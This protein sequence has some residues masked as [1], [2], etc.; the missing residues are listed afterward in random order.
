MRRTVLG[1][2]ICLLGATAFGQV[3]QFSDQTIAG[4]P[5]DL[6]VVRHLVIRGDNVSIGKKL[7]QIGRERHHSELFKLPSPAV[8]TEQMNWMRANYPER[9]AR[10]LGVRTAYGLPPHSNYDITFVPID[11]SLKPACSVVFYPGSSVTNGHAMLSRNYDFPKASYAQITGQGKGAGVRSMTGD[12]YVIEMHPDKGFASLFLCAYDLEGAAID[13]VN[14]KGVTVA[15]LSDDMTKDH[16]RGRPGYGLCEADVTRF[17]LDKCAN[18]KEARRLL[19]DIPYFTFFGVCHYIIG[20]A[21]G[22]SFVFEIGPD[23]K[24]YVIDGKG[25][26]QIVTNH[27]I[28]EYG[29]KNLPRGDSFDRYKRLQQE[30]AKRKGKV[31]PLEVKEI[32]SCVAVPANYMV[33]A[34]LWHAVYDLKDLSLKVSFCLSR[35][36]EAKERRTPYLQFKLK[37]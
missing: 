23:G 22:D 32:N 15:L 11:M 7:A 3:T 5:K 33:S 28:A 37:S 1:L 4:T 35:A 6:M 2:G 17:V 16:K 14:A 34:T 13:G 8:G 36:D 27:S 18:A 30:E 12:P 9:Y 20:D 19:K 24:H 21:S 26:P 25:A 31:T 10:A 29:T